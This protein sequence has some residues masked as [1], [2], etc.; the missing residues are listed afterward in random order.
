MPSFE[1][2]AMVCDNKGITSVSPSSCSVGNVFWAKI[3]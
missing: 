2:M 1:I 3:E